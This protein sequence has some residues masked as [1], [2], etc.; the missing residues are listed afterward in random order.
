MRTR[1]TPALALLALLICMFPTPAHAQ[2]YETPDPATTEAG[3]E[4][5]S[6]EEPSED[7]ESSEE[8]AAVTEEAGPPWT[9][10]M[11]RMTIGLTVLMLLAIGMAYYRFVVRRQRGEV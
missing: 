9:Y 2:K 4:G 3:A 5:S 10:Q 6:E 1:L 8:D 11:A 7:E